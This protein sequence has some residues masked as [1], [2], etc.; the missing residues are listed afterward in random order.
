[1]DPAPWEDE[2]KKA[3][4]AAGDSGP[5]PVGSYQDGANAFGLFDVAGHVAEWTSSLPF[6]RTPR[7]EHHGRSMQSRIV[8][9][10]SS[11]RGTVEARSA[12]R[13]DYVP[14]FW[15]DELG[16]R[17]AMTVQPATAR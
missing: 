14:I 8:R 11:K 17:P 16:L 3:R 13:R 2:V 1:V 7:V 4:S 10:G 5:A 12:A 9:G 15:G 6:A